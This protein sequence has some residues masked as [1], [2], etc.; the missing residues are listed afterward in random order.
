MDVVVSGRANEENLTSVLNF[1]VEDAP[2]VED[3]FLKELE[4]RILIMSILVKFQKMHLF[5]VL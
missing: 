2:P 1:R 4:D 3:Q 5:M